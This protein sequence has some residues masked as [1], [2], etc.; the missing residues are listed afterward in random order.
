MRSRFHKMAELTT[1]RKETLRAIALDRGIPPLGRKSDILATINKF[2][3]P[4]G[5][6]PSLPLSEKILQMTSVSNYMIAKHLSI[7]TSDL[8]DKK[9]TRN[10][11]LEI[12]F[13]EELDEESEKVLE[14]SKLSLA[15]LKQ[16]S[17][18]NTAIKSDMIRRLLHGTDR[19]EVTQEILTG[20]GAL[21]FTLIDPI[22][23]PRQLK[24]I[25]KVPFSVVGAKTAISQSRDPRK[26]PIDL[27]VGIA[28]DYV[29][30]R[31]KLKD[32]EIVDIAVNAIQYPVL[33]SWQNIKKYL[34]DKK[35]EDLVNVAFAL[36]YP[37]LSKSQLDFLFSRGYVLGVER[38]KE[39]S[40]DLRNILIELYGDDFYSEMNDDEPN[41]VQW[42]QTFIEWDSLPLRDLI[43]QT[44]D[45]GV[46]INPL[47]P[48]YL[49]DIPLYLDVDKYSIDINDPP[50]LDE[51]SLARYSDYA[52]ID[53]FPQ[54]P[55]RRQLLIDDFIAYWER[56]KYF[57]HDGKFY[58]GR[59]D[60]HE[61]IVDGIDY[62]TLGLDELI[63][64]SFWVK[65]NNEILQGILD[66]IKTYIQSA[67]IEGLP[68]DLPEGTDVI[69]RSLRNLGSVA[70]GGGGSVPREPNVVNED[71]YD[72]EYGNYKNSVANFESKEIL[73]QMP[74]IDIRKLRLS[75]SASI[76]NVTE[77]GLDHRVFD[78]T[79]FYLILY[80][81]ELDDLVTMARR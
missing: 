19:D 20:L 15:R 61:E 77:R 48:D 38:E 56:E 76:G 6:D 66:E 7:P 46:S 24:E 9:I 73:D 49:D 54:A 30:F 2:G 18:T 63:D 33:S 23:Q 26:I 55:Y 39:I 78:S 60:A 68:D 40:E 42:V 5:I 3:T 51:E 43:E 62:N 25:G 64:L 4:F 72:V 59:L 79:N 28:N 16:L 81:N 11:L 17:G 57:Y 29:L 52:L 50:A 53:F 27:L 75:S 45:K 35:P 80:Y 37:D 41:R 44:R 70:Y 67:E 13:D 71:L 31:R 14:Y 8:R 22:P 21:K 34:K 32:T 36:G 47:N 65:D 69:L 1:A 10:K 12:L 74:L 58:K